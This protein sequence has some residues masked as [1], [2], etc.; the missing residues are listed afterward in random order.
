MDSLVQLHEEHRVIEKAIPM[1][2]RVAATFVG[3][4][5][6]LEFFQVFLD[7]CHHGKEE[8]YLFP[9]LD[10]RGVPHREGFLRE[11]LVEHGLA[12]RYLR[13]LAGLLHPATA[14]DDA[15]SRRLL[16]AVVPEL[17]SLLRDH[18]AKEDAQLW[19]LAAQTLTAEDDA[20]LLAGFADLEQHLIGAQQYAKY[21]CW[22]RLWA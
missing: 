6:V 5:Q 8:L 7:K 3:A 22:A 14:D 1:L 19:P 18:L 16:D 10:A 17:V 12:R 13:D 21:L 15:N 2:E 20:S 4:D 11:L 9:A